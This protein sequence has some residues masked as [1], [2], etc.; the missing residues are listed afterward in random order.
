MRLSDMRIYCILETITERKDI[1]KN[2]GIDDHPK[3]RIMIAGEKKKDI[4]QV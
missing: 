2:A 1:V 3:E 4:T